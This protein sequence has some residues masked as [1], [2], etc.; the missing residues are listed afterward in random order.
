CYCGASVAEAKFLN[1]IYDELSAGWLPPHCRDDALTAEFVSLG[2]DPSGGWLY[3]ADKNRTQSLTL[4]QVGRYADIQ[5][6]NFHMSYEWHRQHCFFL[7]R[8]EHRMKARGRV[9]DPRSD[10]EHHVKHC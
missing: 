4:E 7:W 8:K 3:W 2:D 5:P 10:S 6:E 1:C 9:F